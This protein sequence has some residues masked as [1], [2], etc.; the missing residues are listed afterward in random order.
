M[1][2]TTTA[3]QRKFVLLREVL[4]RIGD[5]WTMLVLQRLDSDGLLRFS[6]L[7]DRIGASQKM[8]TSTLRRLERDGLV[9]RRV[10]P[11]IPPRV[12]YELTPLGRTLAE[13]VCVLW[14]WVDA[15]L[16]EVEAARCA[17][18]QQASRSRHDPET[19]SSR[20]P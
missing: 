3:E 19:P 12:D 4:D 6:Q 7:R 14:E 8:L 18:D 2:D 17:F 1:R 5:R 9:S 10:H 16:C 15:N 11:V 20:G 13:A